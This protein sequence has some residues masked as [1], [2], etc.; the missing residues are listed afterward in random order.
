MSKKEPRVVSLEYPEGTAVAATIGGLRGTTHSTNHSKAPFL[1]RWH[2]TAALQVADIIAIMVSL[3]LPL[4]FGRTSV[5]DGWWIAEALVAIV[6]LY[7]ALHAA[8]GYSYRLFIKPGR[9]SV[10]VMAA[11]ITISAPLFILLLMKSMYGENDERFAVAWWYIEVIWLLMAI[12][13]LAVWIHRRLSNAG[14]LAHAVCV[15][16][17]GAEA[18]ACV[19]HLEQDKGNNLL[20]GY[21][22][23]DDH[24]DGSEPHARYLGH[25][26]RLGTFLLNQ[27]VD[28]VIVATAATDTERLGDLISDLRSLPVALSIWPETLNL[29]PQTI[30]ANHDRLGTIPFLAVGSP[31]LNGWSWVVKDVQDRTLAAL[32]LLACMPALIAIAIA[33]RVRDPG[34]VFF[35]QMREGYCGRQ[36]SIFKFRSMRV[37][38]GQPGDK[39]VLTTRNDNRTFPLGA[40]LRKTSL[41]ELPQLFNVLLGDMWLIGPRPHSPLAT[42]ADRPYAAAVERYAA[43][44]KI[45][46]G[47]TGWAQ[48]NGWRGPTNTIEQIEQRVNHDLYYIEHW[49]PLLDMRILMMTVLRGFSHGNAF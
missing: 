13:V 41:D 3:T 48:I 44:H 32:L 28:E 4:A 23:A 39:L 15:I 43:R 34:P 16:G 47:I 26:G 9:S 31:P 27:R 17:D 12:R 24:R 21:F 1:S 38:P 25:V 40:W 11:L 8:G 10:T 30:S 33:I 19:R 29:R 5:R 49:S 46:P 22:L 42:A 7:L 35:R 20:L 37:D 2:L 36:F 18:R 45:K 6:P 14:W